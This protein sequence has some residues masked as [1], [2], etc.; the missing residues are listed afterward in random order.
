MK[1][2]LVEDNEE[3]NFFIT[4]TFLKMNYSVDSC[5]GDDSDKVF[6]KVE[7][8]FDLYIIDINLPSINGLELVKKIKTNR[9]N[10]TI[11][12]ISGDDNI[13]TILEAYDLGCNDYIK[14]PF[15]LREVV[16]KVNLAFQEKINNQIK[17]SDDCY[18]DKRSKKIFY[19]DEIIILTNR[20]ST[21][22]NQLVI[23]KGNIVPNKVLETAVWG[24]EFANGHIRQ[25]I[26]KLKKILPCSDII[27]NHSKNGYGIF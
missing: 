12:I 14:K 7:Q 8:F 21:L 26:S 3:L 15:D 9:I 19:N 5:I 18:Y 20:E 2:F 6:E 25:L 24:E 10:A 27:Q 1:I 23:N 16:A 22:L 13:E 17:L 11:F 4:D